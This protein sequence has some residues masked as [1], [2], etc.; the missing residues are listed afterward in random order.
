MSVDNVY[1][2]VITPGIVQLPTYADDCWATGAK[3]ETLWQGNNLTIVAPPAAIVVAAKLVRADERDI[4][5]CAF[6]IEAKALA[7]ADIKLA[8]AK[9]P[10]RHARITAKE[11]LVFLSIMTP[12]SN[13]RPGR[14]RDDVENQR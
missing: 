13:E 1:L 2:Q 3:S 12:Q 11:N 6:L 9:I 8:V 14:A 5:D 10:D 7:I 4:D